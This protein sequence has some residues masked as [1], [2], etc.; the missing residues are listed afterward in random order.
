M[1]DAVAAFALTA[2]L[3]EL[4]PGPNMAYLA[5][6]SATEGRKPGYAAVAGVA[7][8]LAMMG[9][10]A[11]LGLAVVI[12][13]SPLL[14]QILSWSGV[15]YLIWLAIDGWRDADEAPEHAA[16]GSTLFRYFQRG[17]VTNLLNPKAAIF[18]ITVLPEFLN[19]S[20]DIAGSIMLS[21]IYVTIAT[22]IHLTIV[23]AAGLTHNWLADPSRTLLVRRTLAV[24]LAV[25]A[26]WLL[27][28]G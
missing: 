27:V 28:K 23:S 6:I 21:A 14:Y 17:L 13:Q 26:L 12:A 22:A 1:P 18:Y 9:L 19:I 8:G 10:A 11:G 15:A 2:L 4:T 3:I 25:V 20:D 7:L 24:A 5:L 16:A